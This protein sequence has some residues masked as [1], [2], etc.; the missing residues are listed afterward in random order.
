MNKAHFIDTNGNPAGGTTSGVGFAIGW[1]NGPLNKGDEK[2]PRNGAFV[3]DIISAA[4]DRLEFYQESKFCCDYNAE[5]I[6]HLESAINV[7]N[8]R[9][10]N[11]EKRGVEGT[12]EV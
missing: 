6:K 7:L 1:Q 9:T 8:S 2:M 10:A 5:A 3:E 12:H 4:K 11:R